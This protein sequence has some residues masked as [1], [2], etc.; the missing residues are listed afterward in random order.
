MLLS[1]IDVIGRLS[2]LGFLM[3]HYSRYAIE[4][5]CWNVNGDG[6]KM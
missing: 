2:L 3:H 4:L 5:L 6:A 1:Q